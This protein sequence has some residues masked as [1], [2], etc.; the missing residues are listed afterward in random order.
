MII[1]STILGTEALIELTGISLDAPASAFIWIFLMLFG[2]IF[3]ANT[4]RKEQQKK[5]A[6]PPVV[7]APEPVAKA[8]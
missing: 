2:I 7:V 3:Q 1:L 4:W 6:Q 8:N 5:H